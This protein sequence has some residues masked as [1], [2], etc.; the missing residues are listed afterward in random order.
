MSRGLGKLQQAILEALPGY[1][2]QD[3][4]GVYA[5]HPLREALAVQWGMTY[6]RIKYGRPCGVVIDSTF[7]ASFARA[8]RTLVARG[9]L[10]RGPSPSWKSREPRQLQ[11]V[12]V[13]KR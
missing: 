1:A 6:P 10:S 2:M 4:P 7:A 9:L 5:L 8:V 13:H 12:R 3:Y 11:Y